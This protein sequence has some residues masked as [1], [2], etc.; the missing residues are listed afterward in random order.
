MMMHPNNYNEQAALSNRPHTAHHQD[1]SLRAFGRPM[2]F[3][4]FIVSIDDDDTEQRVDL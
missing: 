4:Q 1:I 3:W 2:V